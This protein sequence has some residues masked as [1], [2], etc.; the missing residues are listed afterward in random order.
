MS[1]A[2]HQK[3]GKNLQDIRKSRG[4]SLDAVAE[5]SGVSKGM[6]GQIE[7]GESNPTISILWKIVNGL[8]ISFAALMEDASPQVSI[9]KLEDTTPLIAEDGAY[10]TYPIFPFKQDR[11]F[12]VYTVV[13]EPFTSHTSEAHYEG[14]EEFVIA[15][16]GEL[17]VEVGE[18]NYLLKPSL[19]MRFSGDQPHTYC[20]DTDRTIRF[21]TL[22]HYPSS[23]R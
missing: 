16:D 14:V 11:G 5:L 8:R 17:R 15:M 10:R 2:I 9:V 6:L 19:A 20:N 21:T 1:E 3:I 7:R 13:V 23:N 18:D 4:L 12:E 22:I